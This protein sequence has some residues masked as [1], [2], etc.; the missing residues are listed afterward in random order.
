M[1]APLRIGLLT[2]GWPG[3]NTPNGIATAVY[4]LATGLMET[5]QKPVILTA[6]VD[7][8]CP[9][10]IPV[11]RLPELRWRWQDRLRA[12][13]GDA[14][15][16]AHR[17]TA[18]S[19][20]MA[21]NEA[22][23]EHAL[24]VVIME[25]TNGWAAMVAP[26]VPVPVIVTLHG[27]WTIL[28]AHAS[29][30]DPSQD[31]KREAREAIGFQT[32]AGIIAPSQNV[33]STVEKAVP[34]P[35]QA[36]TVIPNAYTVPKPAE[37]AASSQPWDILFVGRVD[38]LKGA[39]VVL[40]A[41]ALLSQTHPQARLTFVGDGQGV[42]RSDGSRVQMEEMLADLPDETRANI[43]YKGRLGR[44]EIARLRASH[45]IVLIAS[46]YEVFPYTMLEAMA[47][48][49]AIVSSAVGGPGET[50][51]HDETALL[52]PPGNPHAM[53]QALRRLL[54]EPALA[55]QL[56]EAVRARLDRDYSPTAIAS[57]VTAFV[58]SALARPDG[59]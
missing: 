35:D 4:F 54:D 47:A 22:V 23:R 14:A 41:F 51:E 44:E 13:F 53:A 27:P 42:T 57:R 29:L 59:G 46:R 6:R 48:G 21:I 15:L 26:L 30:G 45:A 31:E 24:D 16:E 50:L 20:A 34:L 19:I 56:G 58:K 18:R 17:Q 39:D 3:Q 38:F 11:V 43:D 49:Q 5:G 40:E 12:R 7:G 55:A 25:E 28:K 2:P 52:V 8:P 9:E 10:E 32:A 37:L 36:K 33:L 1:T